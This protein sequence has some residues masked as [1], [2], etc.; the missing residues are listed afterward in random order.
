VLGTPLDFRIV[1]S[2]APGSGPISA[3]QAIDPG[4]EISLTDVVLQNPNG[5]TGSLVVLRNDEVLWE[6]ALENFRDLDYHFVAPYGFAPGD[7]VI[8]QMTCLTAGDGPACE[9]AASF[10]GF[11]R[12]A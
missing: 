7:R 10:T 6:T 11:I 2:A 4:S 5:D 8:L 3:E 1:V 12:D 9:A